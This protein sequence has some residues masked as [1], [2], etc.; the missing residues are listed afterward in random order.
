MQ[1][2]VLILAFLAQ[3]AVGRSHATM[4]AALRPQA[5]CYA[6]ELAGVT[7]DGETGLEWARDSSRSYTCAGSMVFEPGAVLFARMTGKTTVPETLTVAFSYR[8][9]R[10]RAAPHVS[11]LMLVRE[12]FKA[13]PR[14][15]PRELDDCMTL[16]CTGVFETGLGRATTRRTRDADGKWYYDL[17]VD[18]IVAP[19]PRIR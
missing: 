9:G 12:V 13:A 5:M 16:M 10:S 7:D 18:I 1:S 8:S 14:V 2:T 6:F 15:L 17:R 4:I 3:S 19:M 11:F